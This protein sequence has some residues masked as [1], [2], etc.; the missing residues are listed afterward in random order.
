MKLQEMNAEELRQ[1][2]CRMVEPM[3][4]IAEDAGVQE[5]LERLW[6][7]DLKRLPLGQGLAALVRELAPVLLQRHWMDTLELLS[8]CTGKDC[9]VLRAQNGM[10]TAR[11]LAT[12][13]RE[14]LV[15]FFPCAAGSARKA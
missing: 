4:R 1:A 7:A 10:D 12:C 9:A 8:I 13:A 6:S 2:L 5:A 14:V 11:E 3:C 15:D